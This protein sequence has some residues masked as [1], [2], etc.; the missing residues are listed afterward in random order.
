MLT[1]A[2]LTAVMGAA[3]A[4]S[5]FGYGVNEDNIRRLLESKR[6]C[7]SARF[8]VC[9]LAGHLMENEE[10]EELFGNEAEG[11]ERDIAKTGVKAQ[12]ERWKGI[13]PWL[14]IFEEFMA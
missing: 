13:N 8:A 2:Q 7:D 6:P 1:E 4:V 3:Y 10:H 14:T 11:W 9:E 5:N 12:I